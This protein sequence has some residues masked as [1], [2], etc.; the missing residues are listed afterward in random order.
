MGLKRFFRFIV[1]LIFIGL[2]W[3]FLF[4]HPRAVQVYYPDKNELFLVPLSRPVHQLTP[5]VIVQ[6]L[7]KTPDE[8]SGLAPVFINH[9]RLP[10]VSAHGR[11]IFVDFQKFPDLANS[12]LLLDALLASFK[13][14]PDFDEVE[15]LVQGR[16]HAIVNGEE[17]GNEALSEFS[18]NDNLQASSPAYRGS[19]R[20]AVIYYLLRGTPYLVPVTQEI[21]STTSVE[22]AVADAL[23]A[24]TYMPW[25]LESALPSGSRVISAKRSRGATVTLHVDL[26]GSWREQ[27]LARKALRLTYTELPAAA[28][29]RIAGSRFWGGEFFPKKR[30]IWIN[31][32]KTEP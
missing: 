5:E 20:K 18:I 28:R 9:D 22:S 10:R 17:L 21:S 19:G 7:G 15:F 2:A 24:G 23:N 27:A 25:A 12:P 14:L 30:P 26:R 29:V 3:R 32:E 11:T 4:W 31:R 6:E 13:Q 1:V 16:A 8:Q